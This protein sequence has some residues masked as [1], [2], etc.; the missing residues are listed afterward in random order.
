VT[1]LHQDPE[2]LCLSQ[3][4]HSSRRRFLGTAAS[5]AGFVALCL[6]L[7]R[8]SR[9]EDEEDAPQAPSIVV[10]D[11]K[12]CVGCRICEVECARKNYKTY[13]P[14]H[15]NLQI[16][17]LV[18][19]VSVPNH[20]Y[21]CKDAPCIAECPVVVDA[22]TGKMALFHDPKAKGLKL[23][24]VACTGCWKCVD[25]C[26]RER[27]GILR[28]NLRSKRP[29]GF[30]TLCD[31]DPSCVKYCPNDAMARVPVTFDGRYMARNPYL[32]GSELA[33]QWYR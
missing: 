29:E 30:C 9:G 10:V 1:T 33:A 18:P 3:L 32:L 20:C 25:V 26:Q 31:G 15:A 21:L 8:P 11:V 6:L 22:S 4:T 28:K 12:K 5:A 27:S 17:H 7:P 13:N 14:R 2:A 16:I 23:D 19:P 24:N